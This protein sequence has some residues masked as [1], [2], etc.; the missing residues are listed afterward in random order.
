MTKIKVVDSDVFNNFF[1]HDFLIWNHLRF[2]NLILS[3]HLLKFKILTV[4]IW[5]N[6]KMTKIKV[7]D[8]DVFKNFYFSW[9]SY[10][11]PFKVS[12]SY[13]K[14]T[15]I[16]IQNL[17]CSNLVK[18]KDDQNISCIYWWV[19]QLWYSWVFQLKSFTLSKC[20]FKLKL[21]EFQILNR[22]NKVTWQ[23]DQNKSCR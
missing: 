6:E 7:E 2:Q 9:L 16:E 18:W 17:N 14:L 11:K 13:L 5:S 4:Q 8:S 10:L 19:L 12:K 15:F 20:C 22:S 3:W 23:D 21:F 1:V